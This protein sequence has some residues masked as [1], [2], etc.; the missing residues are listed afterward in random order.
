MADWQGYFNFSGSPALKIKVA[1]RPS[2]ASEYEAIID[3]G[4]N[5]FLSILLSALK[6]FKK[7]IEGVQSVTFAD[8]SKTLRLRVIATIDVEGYVITGRAVVEPDGSERLVGMQFLEFC[9]R[10][11][12]I[13]PAKNEVSLPLDSYSQ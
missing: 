3:T 2:E 8:G 12:I 1:V 6:I 10:G 4:F 5:G 11:L 7:Q 9:N 13:F